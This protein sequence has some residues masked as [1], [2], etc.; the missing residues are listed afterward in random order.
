MEYKGTLVLNRSELSEL[1]TLDEY[2]D[3]IEDAFR[4]HGEGKSFGTDMIHGDTPGDLEFHIKAGGLRLGEKL[5]Y[6]L[7]MNGS[8]FKNKELYNLPNILGAILLFDGLTGYPLAVMDSIE[9]TIKRTGAGTAVAL[10]YLARADSKILTVCG[11]GNQGRIQGKSAKAV[12]PLEKIFAYDIN[13]E[14]ARRYAQEIK[15]ELGIEVIATEDL[16]TAVGDSDVVITCTPSREPYL[17][18]EFVKLGTT[19][20]A[21]GADSPDKQELESALFKGNKVVVDILAQCAVAGELHHALEKNLISVGDVHAEIGSIIAG[22]KPGREN[23]DE[24]IIYDAT[25]TAIQDTAAAAICYEKA[26]QLDK[27]VYIN[28]QN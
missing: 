22:R 1:M 25:G 28:L 18:K 3:G 6:G 9:P 2:I 11:C 16:K 19:V 20:T 13:H 21:I 4:K 12:L 23:Q 14:F 10:K 24:I 15:K 26:K 8:C 7:K 5:Y 17:L 27:G